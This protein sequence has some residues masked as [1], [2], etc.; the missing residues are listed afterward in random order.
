MMHQITFIIITYDNMQTLELVRM[1]T[2]VITTC[3]DVI[4]RLAD[5]IK[6]C[7]DKHNF[8]W[9]WMKDEYWEL[10]RHIYCDRSEIEERRYNDLCYE[11]KW[12]YYTYSSYMDEHPELENKDEY[13]KLKYRLCYLR[14]KD[15]IP[16]VI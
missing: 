6:D 4:I 1:K 11:S 8:M 14:D 9:I 10:M 2:D 3:G 15:L 7:F 16:N 5:F 12:E 13:I